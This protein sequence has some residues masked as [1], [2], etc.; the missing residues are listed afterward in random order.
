LLA[1]SGCRDRLVEVEDFIATFRQAMEEP[2]PVPAKVLPFRMPRRLV[3]APLAAAAALFLGIFAYQSQ[4]DRA[5][6][7]A[8]LF[9]Q[10][11]RGPEAGAEAEAD[12]PLILV[13]NLQ[14]ETTGGYAAEIVDGDG[15]QVSWA[16]PELLEGRLSVKSPGLDA[17]DYWVR[18]YH[19][20]PEFEQI[21]EYRLRVQ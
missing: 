11:L 12:R 2:E 8:I 3:W 17:G 16:Q 5:M 10:P 7:P 4:E 15:E 21:H 9:L 14:A 18:L 6:E 1:C 13:L 19:R 20:R